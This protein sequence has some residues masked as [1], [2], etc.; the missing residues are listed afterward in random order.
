MS[1]QQHTPE[2]EQTHM[3]SSFQ[4][5]TGC[6]AVFHAESLSPN[7][8]HILV[9]APVQ[10]GRSIIAVSPSGGLGMV[11]EVMALRKSL[12]TTLTRE[13]P[14]SLLHQVVQY[15]QEHMNTL[16]IEAG[17]PFQE[18]WDFSH[19]RAV[20]LA[21]CQQVMLLLAQISPEDAQV[22]KAFV[23]TLARAAAGAGQERGVCGFA[24]LAISPP[25]LELLKEIEQALNL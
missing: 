20:A 9:C 19:V 24:G 5:G 15:L 25:E 14:H 17:A 10:M 4:H 6:S 1:L 16:W 12:Q 21:A 8:W 11:Q 3:R 2:E 18:D 7:E 23:S 22:Y 13:A